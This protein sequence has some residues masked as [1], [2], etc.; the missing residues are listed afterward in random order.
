MNVWSLKQPIFHRTSIGLVRTY[1]VTV[2]RNNFLSSRREWPS[3]LVHRALGMSPALL[4][5]RVSNMWAYN[6]TFRSITNDSSIDYFQYG[7][8]CET[9]SKPAQLQC[10]MISHPGNWRAS[11][12]RIIWTWRQP[13]TN[14]LQ[15]FPGDSNQVLVN[16][17]DNVSRHPNSR[18]SMQSRRIAMKQTTPIILHRPHHPSSWHHTAARIP[19]Y[20]PRPV[21]STSV[22]PC[23][24]PRPRPPSVAALPHWGRAGRR[25]DSLE[26]HELDQLSGELGQ[27][28]GG[29][30]CLRVGLGALPATQYRLQLCERDTRRDTPVSP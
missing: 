16:D 8:P 18:N 4:L 23:R 3:M 22:R 29:Q 10:N 13:A 1:T 20:C 2:S 12:G 14:G 9:N 24:L 25:R 19:P 28:V 5:R 26:L 30:R 27:H 6:N 7:P 21:R 17:H 11:N 15:Q